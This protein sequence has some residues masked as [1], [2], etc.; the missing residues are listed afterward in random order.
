ME[1]QEN[2]SADQVAM[3]P[4]VKIEVTLKMFPA[5]WVVE[6]FAN[7]IARSATSSSS[8]SSLFR[9]RLLRWLVHA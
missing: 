8:N 2:A 5:A 9:L 3:T 7:F 4:A 1:G 6:N